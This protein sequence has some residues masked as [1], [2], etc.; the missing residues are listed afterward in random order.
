M[1][2]RL[3]MF[4]KLLPLLFL[5]AGFQV[6]AGII[7]NVDLDHGAGSVFGTIETDGTIGALSI[8]NVINVNLSMQSSLIGGG[9]LQTFS[10]FGTDGSLFT[11]SSTDL[12]FDFINNT[13]GWFTIVWFLD[14]VSNTTNYWCLNG[15]AGSCDG[16]N[17]ASSLGYGAQGRDNTIAGI[18]TIASTAV[19]VPEP[20]IIALFALGLVGI[21]FAR[22]RQS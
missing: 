16:N 1:I 11:A 15:S 2:W 8:G 19:T 17:S 14:T 21:G 9:N 10:S 5:F 18:T 12:N 20:S 4:K 6:N 7:Y 22:R 13:N 3:F